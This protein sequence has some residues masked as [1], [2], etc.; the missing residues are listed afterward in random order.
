[1]TDISNDSIRFDW[2]FQPSGSR[3]FDESQGSMSG[4]A[5]VPRRHSSGPKT[6][7]KNLR[8]LIPTRFNHPSGW[9]EKDGDVWKEFNTNGS[10]IYTFKELSKDTVYINLF[11]DTRCAKVRR[12]DAKDYPD[13]GRPMYFRIPIA[14][15]PAQWTYP[16]PIEW[17]DV[18][19]VSPVFQNGSF[20]QRLM[21]Q[22]CP[23]CS[24]SFDG[25][26]IFT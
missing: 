11:D 12:F 9:F 3:T 26:R 8:S 18:M 14:G 20:A 4:S 19:I 15:G 7:L 2:I 16:N 13:H 23:F 21:E 6:I 25:L 10:C 5:R 24:M 22:N 1:V 17:A